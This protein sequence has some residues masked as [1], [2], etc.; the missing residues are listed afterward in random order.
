[1]STL[2]PTPA[3]V[4]VGNDAGWALTF[5]HE[6]GGRVRTGTPALTLSSEDLEADIEAVLAPS[7]TGLAPGRF[8]IRIVGLAG[9]AFARIDRTAAGTPRVVRLYLFW[10][11]LRGPAGFLAAAA[12]LTGTAGALSAEALAPYLVAELEI[13][14]VVRR[15]GRLR[16]E[17]T[18]EASERVYA[19]LSATAATGGWHAD[20]IVG[21]VER[22][23][24]DA[25]VTVSSH[26]LSRD[27]RVTG[28]GG[29]EHVAVRPGDPY[30]RQ[31]SELG[32]RIADGLGAHGRGMLLIRRGELIVGKRPIPLEGAAP[33]ALALETGLLHV[34][35]LAP[36][37]AGGSGSARPGS[38]P[39][40]RN[41]YRLIL[42]GRPDLLPGDTVSLERP[43]TSGVGAALAEG[44]PLVVYL[45]T[46]AHRHGR[47]TGFVTTVSGCELAGVPGADDWDRA[48]RL[49]SRPAGG[50]PGD[51]AG[52]AHVGALVDRIAARAARRIRTAEVAEVR[53][54]SPGA[55][56]AQGD[57]PAQ[58]LTLWRGLVPPDGSANGVSRREVRRREPTRLE[59][60][61]YLT[62]FAWGKCGL[63]LPRYPGTRVVVVHGEGDGA[64]PVDAGAVWQAGHAPTTAEAGDWWLI[65][66]VG[67]EASRRASAQDAET[68][69]EEHTGTATNDL[70]DADG[71]RVIEVGELTVRVGKLGEAGTRPARAADEGSVTI[72]HAGGG[73]RI[74]IGK[75]GAVTVHAKKDL[76]LVSEEGS[77]SLTATAGGVKVKVKDQMTVET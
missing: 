64:D 47:D 39:P 7:P 57:P 19:R 5:H 61:P 27:G 46:V 21:G 44:G 59:R 51:G 56:A 42:K 20:T 72:E 32:T 60:V 62:P 12:G 50:D 74:V 52:A 35:P 33:V 76:A 28:S 73:A 54:A 22:M 53:S 66:P 2:V 9:D 67:V 17:T 55:P 75:D 70:I 30:A 1:M 25:G 11:D 41:R 15:P 34:E 43:A 29:D 65:L 71:N 45:E 31:V 68:P 36:D 24:G 26:G 16:Y 77:I 63:V 13:A 40:P 14:S 4:S 69:P 48:P 6:D 38:S 8:V 3:A 37:D 10:R 18:I 58:T 23:A 49:R